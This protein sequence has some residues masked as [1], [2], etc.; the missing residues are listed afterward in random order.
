MYIQM[1]NTSYI[2]NT[3]KCIIRSYPIIFS[4]VRK[5]EECYSMTIEESH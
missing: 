5:V 1:K 3:I 2:K 4:Y